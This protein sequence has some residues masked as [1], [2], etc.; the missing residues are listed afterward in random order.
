M[1]AQFD[2]LLA[3]ESLSTVRLGVISWRRPVPVLPR[4]GFTLCD[5]RTVLIAF[6][7]HEEP[8]VASAHDRGS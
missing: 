6:W 1:L 5:Q 7:P 2:R 4:H 8:F 3:M